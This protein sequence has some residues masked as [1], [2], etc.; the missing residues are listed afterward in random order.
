[1][2]GYAQL[3]RRGRRWRATRLS[4]RPHPACRYPAR[5][6][7]R[8]PR[9]SLQA[10]A[11]ER[12][13]LSLLS[14]GRAQLR[15]GDR[16]LHA[17]AAPALP[18]ARRFRRR[19]L[20]GRVQRCRL[21]L[22]PRGSGTA[23]RLCAAGDAPASRRPLPRLR[24]RP[25]RGGR[26]PGTLG[27]ASRALLQPESVARRRALRHPAAPRLHGRAAGTRARAHVRVQPQLGRRAVQPVR[28]DG[29]AQAAPAPRS[30]RLRADRRPAARRLRA[31]R[32]LG[33][34]RD[35][36]ARRRHDG[37]RLRRGARRFR[38][39]GSARSTSK[40]SMATRCRRSTRSTPRTASDCRRSGIRARA[41][42]GRTTFGNIPT[43]S[44]LRALALL[45][46]S[47]SDRVRRACD[48]RRLGRARHAPQFHR[49][50]QRPRP[51]AA[52]RGRAGLDRDR[53]TAS[54]S[55]SRP[56]TSC[57]CCSGRSASARASTIS[58][59]RSRCCR[60]AVASRMRTFFVG[61]REGDYQ[62]ALHTLVG[63]LPDE[64][65]ARVDESFPRPATSHATSSPPTCSC[66]R[67]GSKATR[68]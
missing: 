60:D 65:R 22:P 33:A 6:L 44:P 43:R 27:L 42:R 52:R 10:H 19:A 47:L 21:R 53:G 13:R 61:D 8:P 23:L 62:R 36:S 25:T 50:P 4:R 57:C 31:R 58:R 20:R 12:P 35:A 46:V 9:A 2:V 67:R 66:A 16:R 32:H 38:R 28:N 49:D 26:V 40:S 41:S 51:P 30:G 54:R 5:L 45:R 24:R 15:R 7:R 29:G 63:K 56:T 18:R 39:A 11:G 3:A 34:R 59:R 48:G 1:M 37:T 68:A 64:R 17:D 14:R 55:A